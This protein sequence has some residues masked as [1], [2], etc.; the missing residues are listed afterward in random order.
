[1]IS[2]GGYSLCAR[3]SRIEQSVYEV[4]QFS[5]ALPSQ[6]IERNKLT[7]VEVIVEISTIVKINSPKGCGGQFARFDSEPFPIRHALGVANQVIAQNAVKGSVL[8]FYY[9]R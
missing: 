2:V 4:N 6:V 5:R 7:I 9:K 8:L 1:M 3:R